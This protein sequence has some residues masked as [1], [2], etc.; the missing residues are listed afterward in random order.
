MPA[1]NLTSMP[2]WSIL[3]STVKEQFDGRDRTKTVRYFIPVNPVG[4][5]HITHGTG[6]SGAI[7]E[8]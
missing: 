7:I 1:R 2:S 8:G 3:F 6:G 4:L 5:V